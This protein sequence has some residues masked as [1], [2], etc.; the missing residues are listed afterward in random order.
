MLGLSFDLIGLAIVLIGTLIQYRLD[1]FMRNSPAELQQRWAR[2]LAV[3]TCVFIVVTGFD[4]WQT[5][6]EDRERLHRVERAA[7][8]RELAA[9]EREQQAQKERQAISF[10]IQDIVTLARERNPAL[11]E[12]EALRTVSTELRNLREKTSQL[13]HDLDGLRRYNYIA[14][15]NV[16]GI[17]GKYGKEFK[18][19]SPISRA[20][21]G[22]YDEKEGDNGSSYSPRCD[23]EGI[24]MYANVVRDFPDFPFSHWALTICLGKQ[25]NPQWRTHAKRAKEIF[26]HT[27]QIANHHPHHD[28]VFQ[29]IERL[30][31][32][33]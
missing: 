27:T 19:S 16:L 10:Y 31:A 5:H 30:L 29:Q 20:L 15:Y 17:S 11:T 7:A 8:E 28:V 14:K 22:A 3:L 1:Y 32:Q 24:N 23:A 13:E 9:Q 33:Q 21:E 18:E 2:I 12:Q 4:F 6:V 26:E 25:G